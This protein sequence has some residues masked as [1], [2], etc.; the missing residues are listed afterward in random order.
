MLNAARAHGMPIMVIAMITDAISQPAAIHRPPKAIHST[1]SRSA[2]SDI[3]APRTMTS[4]SPHVDPAAIRWGLRGWFARCRRS[5]GNQ[6]GERPFQA[7]RAGIV[8]AAHLSD[9]RGPFLVRGI[10]GVLPHRLRRVGAER[11]PERLGV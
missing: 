5:A 1:L 9:Q 7:D 2:K 10:V 3:A 8:G 11:Q 4:S 6:L